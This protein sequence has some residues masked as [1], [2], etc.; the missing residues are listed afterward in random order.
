MTGAEEEAGL[1]AGA[2]DPAEHDWT[3][4]V[5]ERDGE[6]VEFDVCRRCGCRIA[7][8]DETQAIPSMDCDRE[9]VKSVMRS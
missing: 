1:T 9:L 4:L 8:T 2:S 5:E 7:R 6:L 3:T